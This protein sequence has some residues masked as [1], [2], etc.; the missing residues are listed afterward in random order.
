M[1]LHTTSLASLEWAEF[2]RHYSGFCYSAPAQERALTLDL[3]QN[4]TDSEWLLRL[5]AEA[6]R[7]LE[8]R[9]FSFLSS[10]PNLDKGFQ[11]LAKGLCL[12]GPELAAFAVLIEQSAQVES[13]LAGKGSEEQFPEW[14]AKLAALHPFPEQRK[15]IVNA[16]QP[17][18]T[19]KDSAS[20]RL[21]KLRREEK[22]IHEDARRETERVLK[23]AHKDGIAQ[24]LFFDV[25]DGRYVIPVKRDARAQVS[26][27]AYE[28]STSKATV[29]V[30]PSSLRD[31]N[32]RIRQIQVDIEEEIYAILRDLSDQLHPHASPLWENY[33]VLL[34]FDLGLGRGRLA[35]D[36]DSYKHASPFEFGDSVDLPAFY[37]PLL[38]QVIPADQV[39]TSDFRLDPNQKAL[40]ISGP[41]T[42][43]KTVLLKALGLCSLMA[44]AGF[45]LTAGKSARLPYFEKILAHIGD[46][47]S[48]AESLSSFSSSIMIIKAILAEANAAT[49]V[50]IDEILASTDPHEASALSRAIL[51][52]LARKRTTTVVTTHFSNLKELSSEDP[53]FLNASMEFDTSEMRPLYR[54]RLGIPGRSWA[55]ETAA[56]LGL[57]R[58]IIEDA[59]SSL[60]SEQVRIDKLIAEIEAKEGAIDVQRA[61]LSEARAAAARELEKLRHL[62]QQMQEERARLRDE[63][64]IELQRAERRGEEKLAA[65]IEE[66]R[67]KI[68]HAPVLQQEMREAKRKIVELRK[69][70]TPEPRPTV[71]E[72]AIPDLPPVVA[73]ASAK[74]VLAQGGTVRIRNLNMTGVL[75]SNPQD[76]SRPAEVQ[77][78]S[79][80]L[81]SPWQQLEALAPPKTAAPKRTSINVVERDPCPP[82][83]NLIGMRVEDALPRLEEYLD[84]ASQSSLVSV[85]IVHGHGT[86]ALKKAVRDTLQ[87]SAY[88]F[89]Y[90][91]GAREEGGDGCTVVELQDV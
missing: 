35:I 11:R 7:L 51:R 91:S 84:R 44:R 31:T 82:E 61:E 89:R 42:G 23:Q 16:I 58:A 46:E 49:L 64:Q 62:R 54:L 9:N 40:I 66:Y 69:E 41:N 71:E 57:A 63:A 74:P 27:V 87:R 13:A 65:L 1:D 68:A 55:I 10:L 79:M 72:P 75:L 22:K 78:G 19:V 21:A 37:H 20:P 26:G 12:S 83:L 24:D 90:R 36:F 81:K 25:R 34:D 15:L 29:Y 70:F 28:S 73:P 4:Q 39:V 76:E 47:Q 38:R 43:G 48:I 8:A 77:V 18:G 88:G 45:F 14:K 30:E 33:V 50:L 32:D 60:G 5:T 2:L 3:P 67:E 56:R 53:L 6:T 80:K 52:E 85:R 86:G 17:D 59:L